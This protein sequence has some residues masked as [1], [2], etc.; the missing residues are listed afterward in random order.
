M[1]EE[2]LKTA[3]ESK[4]EYQNKYRQYETVR[5]EFSDLLRIVP[6]YF[7]HFS[8]HDESHSKNI[9]E[10]ME[11][12]FG[13]DNAEILSSTDLLF[14]LLSAYA[15]DVGMSLRYKDIESQLTSAQWRSK[16]NHILEG[17]EP[18]MKLI[19][20]KLTDYPA[21][22][23]SDEV[24]GSIALYRKI[25]LVFETIFREE[26]ASR[27]AQYIRACDSLKNLLG[28]R[29]T[30]QLAD[31]CRMHEKDIDD[32]MTLP[33]EENGLFGDYVHPRLIASM[34]CFCDLL[35]MDTD[36]F[37]RTMLRAVSDLPKLSNGHKRKHESLR[38][39]LIKTGRVEIKADCPDYEVY[40]LMRGWM[41]WMKKASQ[42]MVYRWDEICPHD[43]IPAPRIK[44][45]EILLQGN[46]KWCEMAEVSLHIEAKHALE[47]LRGTNIYSGKGVFVR[48]L[49]QNSIDASLIQFCRDIKA[50]LGKRQSD[51]LTIEEVKEYIGKAESDD[52]GFKEYGIKGSYCLE[53]GRVKIEII[54]RGAG[55]RREDIKNIA[56]LKGKSENYK[57]EIATFPAMLR[58]SGAFGLGIQSVFQVSDKIEYY[59]K[60]DGEEGKHITIEDYQ[61]GNGYVTVSD[62]AEDMPRGT[63]TV[64]YLD[65]S[66]FSQTDLG[67]SDYVFQTGK[68]EELLLTWLIQHCNNMDNG[69]L[70]PVIKSRLQREDYFPVKIEGYFPDEPK[71]LMDVISRKSMLPLLVQNPEDEINVDSERNILTFCHADCEEALLFEAELK[72]LDGEDSFGKL[73]RTYSVKYCESLWYRNVFV[74]DELV[75][76]RFRGKDRFFDLCDFRINIMSDKADDILNIGRN[77]VRPSFFLK[78]EELVEREVSLMKRAVVDYVINAKAEN[79][80]TEDGKTKNA[81]FGLLF[82]ALMYSLAENSYKFDDLKAKYADK[83]KNM[84]VNYYFPLTGNDGKEDGKEGG[85]AS[86]KSFEAL[87]LADNTIFLAAKIDSK[88]GIIPEAL[89]E[90]ISRT[91]L[92][93][94]RVCR[95]GSKERHIVNHYLTGI[96][97]AKI[98]N[99]FYE[100]C[101]VSAYRK[102][103]QAIKRPDI[104]LL[105]H[106][107]LIICGSR[108]CMPTIPEYEILFTD[109]RSGIADRYQGGREQAIEMSLDSMIK[110]ELCGEIARTG[111]VADAKERFLERIKNSEMYEQN[112]RFIEDYVKRQKKEDAASV[113][114]KYRELWGSMLDILG[115]EKYAEFSKKKGVLLSQNAFAWGIFEPEQPGAFLNEHYI[116]G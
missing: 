94:D 55:I 27:S 10:S 11:K 33:Y 76:D 105:D 88:K 92:D 7:P 59:T 18:D 99:E 37:D 2:L 30:G 60:A 111:Y 53:N 21:S 40:R 102:K 113:R 80:L 77:K 58:P 91:D 34:L 96:C 72:I 15:H 112:V 75:R 13:K 24:N 79:S 5:E 103:A 19:A 22:V 16:L 47:I 64:I 38:H 71:K 78:L 65:S 57:K 62:L 49:L 98:E 28:I 26:H 3:C 35:D 66:R 89:L 52:E 110:K 87:Q 104:L 1:L 6:V 20:E 107:L 93:P 84:K 109:L 17:K 61:G 97:Y 51:D 4:T 82:C 108:R 31:I 43:R 90:E 69:R 8:R 25:Q 29:L 54:D 23:Q 83:L 86:E 74:Q 63:K 81:V 73:E 70:A 42:T 36:R 101:E 67:V 50:Y 9:I 44:Q 85:R 41:D 56:G 12:L 114:D 48:E 68:K 100:I 32:I 106:M 46:S 115:Q 45:C 14:L 116:V 39:F 95:H